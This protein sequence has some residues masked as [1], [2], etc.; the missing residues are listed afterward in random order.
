MASKRAPGQTDNLGTTCYCFFFVH[1]LPPS[2]LLSPELLGVRVQIKLLSDSTA[3]GGII[4]RRCGRK[5][6]RYML[7]NSGARTG[8]NF[9]LEIYSNDDDDDTHTH[10]F[11]CCCSARRVGLRTH[12]SRSMRVVRVERATKNP[13]H[14]VVE[15][16]ATLFLLFH[17]YS[18]AHSPGFLLTTPE[19]LGC[20]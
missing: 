16:I 18:R 10:F 13:G 14:R 9:L 1:R 6:P 20:T 8:T 2:H 7:C 4:P 5:Y 11:S 12:R 17:P 3:D 15:A 19:Y